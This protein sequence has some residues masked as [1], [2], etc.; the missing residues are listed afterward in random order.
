[1]WNLVFSQ[2]NHNP[3]GSY[4]PLPK[5]NIDTGMGLERMVSIMQDGHTNYDTDL[6]L[7]IIR[8]IEAIS[9]KTYGRDQNDD[10]AFRVISDHIRT[11]SFTISDGGLPSNEGRGY[12]IRR[13]LRRAV[14]FGKSLG[15][16]EPF[17]YKLVPFVARIMED[18]YPEVKEKTPFIQKVIK[19]EEDRFHETINEG[20]SILKEMMEAAKEHNREILTG[21]D[22]FKLYDTYGFPL[23]LTEEYVEE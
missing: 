6:F 19:K 18:F 1:I 23:E 22:A 17:M 14:R 15:M 10:N 21:E 2:F 12:V 7:P 13:L 8:E 20:I 3:D 11:V 4:T 16:H 9:G 5:K